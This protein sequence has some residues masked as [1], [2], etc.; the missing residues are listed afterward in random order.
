MCVHKVSYIN[1]APLQVMA[2]LP[3]SGASKL[4]SDS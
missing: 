4:K 2:P 1:F 3:I